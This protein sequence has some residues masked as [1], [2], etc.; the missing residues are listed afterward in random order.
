V[1]ANLLNNAA[2]Y[3]EKGG[4]I[5]LTAERQGSEAIVSVRDTG[6]GIAAEHLSRLFEMFSQVEPALARSQGGLGIGLA[7]VRGLVELHGGKVEVRSAGPGKGSE[8]IV[9]LAL[10]DIPLRPPAEPE[11]LGP[12]PQRRILV[13]D[14]NQ[15]AADSMVMML[16]MMGHETTTAYDGL[17]AVQAAATFRPE[18]VLLDIGLPKMNGYEAAQHI[19]KQPWGTGMALIA[20]TGWGQQDDKRRALAAGFDHHL[21]KPVEAIALDKLLALIGPMMPR[22]SADRP[23]AG[24]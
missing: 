1:F 24:R 21:P 8:F 15:D 5:W 22:W 9:H 16:R 3:T 6:I 17:E 10:V 2:T 11:R 18:V 23:E 13:V 7:L 19:R 14:D 20:L 4:H 12:G